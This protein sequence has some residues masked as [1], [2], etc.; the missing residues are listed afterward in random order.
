MSILVI[1]LI[2]DLE[3]F[4][5]HDDVF[6]FLTFYTEHWINILIAFGCYE[7]LMFLIWLCA[8]ARDARADEETDENTGTCCCLCCKFKFLSGVELFM[9]FHIKFF[10]A[11]GQFVNNF[12]TTC[13]QSCCA[14]SY[15]RKSDVKYELVDRKKRKK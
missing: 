1:S 14:G 15:D 7:V 9:C 10:I 2:F 11:I 6:P 3:E 8:K 4:I 13:C 5:A 12:V